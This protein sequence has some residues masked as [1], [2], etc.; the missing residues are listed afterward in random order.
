MAEKDLLDKIVDALVGGPPKKEG[1]EKIEER[2]EEIGKWSH[3]KN[4]IVELVNELETSYGGQIPEDE[5]VRRG[6]EEGMSE[7]EVKSV[8]DELVDDGYLERPRWMKGLVRR[9]GTRLHFCPW[10]Q[11]FPGA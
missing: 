8:I 7:E 4:L 9:R 5:I 3:N 2:K 6:T 1:K 11:D 10:S